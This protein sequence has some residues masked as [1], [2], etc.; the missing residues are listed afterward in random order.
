MNAI[1]TIADLK[2]FNRP[3]FKNI[4]LNYYFYHRDH[5]YVLF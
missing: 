2:V 4:T 3:T 1:D 5:G